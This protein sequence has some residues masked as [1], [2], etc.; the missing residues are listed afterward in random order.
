M[1]SGGDALAVTSRV[2]ADIQAWLAGSQ[3]SRLVIV[4]RGAVPAGTVPAGSV[5]AGA[6]PAGS[7]P[8]GSVP[9][10]SVPAGSV[11]A[12]S[13]MATDPAAAAVWGLA[14]SAQAENPGSIT[15]L[16]LDPGGCVEQVLGPVLASGEP[17]VAVRGRTLFVPR[18]QR[19]GDRAA[20]VPAVFGPAGT[21]LVSGAGTLGAAVARHLVSRHGVRHLVLASRR[22]PDADGTADLVAELKEEGADVSVAACDLSDR[23]Q[24]AALLAEHRPAGVVHT[25]GVLDDGVIGALTPGR[26]AAVFAPKVDAVAHL[27]EL[28]RDS[29]IGAFVVFSSGSGVFGSPGQGNYAAANAFLDAAMANRRAAGLPGLSLAWGPWEQ[30]AGM[31]A[32]LGGADQARMSRGGVRP[33]TQAEGMDLFDAALASGQALLV[34]VK[35]GLREVRAG[36]SV[37]HL[38]HGLIPPGRQR[39]R[40]TSEGDGALVRRLAGLAAADQEALLLDL[41]RGQAAL[42]LGHSGPGGVRAET[43]FKDAGFDSLTSVELRN[44]LRAGTELKLPATLA[45]DYPTPLLLARHLRDELAAGGNALSQVNARIEEVEALIASLALDESAR[46]AIALRLQGLTARCGGTREQADA[47]TVADQLESASAD[48]VMGFI[49]ELGLAP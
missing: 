21:V 48:E 49:D 40:A 35:L 31:T 44:R 45:F 41:V 19:A 33:M 7:V 1:A 16:D 5:P 32:N 17:Q 26:L 15:L 2:L 9:A 18:L 34:P 29:G 42:V 36:G 13:V 22:G 12:G 24:V 38:L 8:A 43:A 11:P 47:A 28:T 6:M 4:T 37:P 20:G 30:S 23:D 46:S 10:G 27:D 14:R 3:E 25:A 39:A